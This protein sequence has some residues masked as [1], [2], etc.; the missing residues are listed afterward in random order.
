M[1][2]LQELY[3][4]IIASEELKAAFL[5]AAKS[6]KALEFLKEQGCEVTEDE[7]KAFLS[8]KNSGELSDEELDDVAGGCDEDPGPAIALSIVSVGIRCV[9][10]AID[11]AIDPSHC[12]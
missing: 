5:E 1:K 6:G 11:T 4:E 12:C 7:L 3:H 8:K 9:K 10:I 2:T